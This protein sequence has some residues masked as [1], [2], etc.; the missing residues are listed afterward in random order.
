[1]RSEVTKSLEFQSDVKLKKAL[2]NSEREQDSKLILQV[3]Q[4]RIA[5]KTFRQ[6]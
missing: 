2:L 1:M 4:K 6:I 5:A 3:Q